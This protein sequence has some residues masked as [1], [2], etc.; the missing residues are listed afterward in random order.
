MKTIIAT[1]ATLMLLAA[2]PA[3]AMSCCGGQGK[4]MMCGKGGMAILALR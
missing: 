2:S 4:A 1:A 3:L